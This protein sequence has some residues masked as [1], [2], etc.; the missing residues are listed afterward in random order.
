MPT[1]YW[2]TGINQAGNRSFFTLRFIGHAYDRRTGK[3]DLGGFVFREDAFGR[4]LL[5]AQASI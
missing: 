4:E 5:H 2:S 1:K 3:Y